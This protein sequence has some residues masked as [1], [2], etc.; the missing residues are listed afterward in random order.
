MP[1]FTP[2]L[3]L[4]PS[5]NRSG[6]AKYTLEEA[7]RIRKEAKT[8]RKAARDANRGELATNGDANGLLAERNGRPEVNAAN[9]SD[10]SEDAMSTE[11]EDVN[12]AD[13]PESLGKLGSIKVPWDRDVKYW[14]SE[15]EC[16]M[17]IIQVKSQW[18]KR[19]V[20]SNN[21]PSLVKA[22]LKE[23]LKK[24]KANAPADIYKQIKVKTIELFAPREEDAFERAAAL[25]MTAKPS[26]LAKAI[27]E[28]LCE[29]DPPL[30]GCC[31]AKTV[32]ALWKRKLPQQIKTRIAGM[33]LAQ[34]YANVLK[35][36][37]DVFAT[38][39]RPG[40][41]AAVSH[42]QPS[43]AQ[44][45]AEPQLEELEDQEVAAYGHGRGGAQRG[46]QGRGAQRGGQRGRRPGRGGFGGRGHQR[47]GQGQGGRGQSQQRGRG[48]RHPDGPPETAC[49]MH[50]RFG[51][52]AYYCTQEDSCPWALSIGKPPR[53]Q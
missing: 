43:P 14:F 27:T 1:S 12:G 29:C 18:I 15:L 33:S 13:P 23:L 45:A 2:T 44:P 53:D 10:E 9:V 42:R 16:Q 39:Q 3:A 34:D 19:T 49:K 30:T 35:L 36:A 40:S 31:Q 17:D 6:K 22:E 8:Q 24:T 41:V 47:G 26:A 50:W 38:L 7:E 20:L 51:R 5:Q 28:I 11:F 46:A 37:D 48:D 4:E 32:A 52:S 25:E 21:L